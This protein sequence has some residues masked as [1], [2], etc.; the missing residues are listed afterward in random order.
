MSDTVQQI[1]QKL[2][3]V[4]VVSSYIKLH[5]AGKNYKAKSPFTNEKTPSFFVSPDRDMYYCFSS[6][7]GGDIFTFVQEMEGLDFKGALS[8]LAERAGVDIIPFRSESKDKREKLFDLMEEATKYYCSE[9]MQ[10]KEVQQY[11]KGRGLAGKTCAQW[12]VGYAPPG[13][14]TGRAALRR[15]RFTDSDL[16]QA[17]LIKKS[18]K[19][20]SDFYDRFRGRIMFPI[21]DS[22]GR[23]IAFSGRI[24]PSKNNVESQKEDVAKYLNSPDTVLYNK[25]HVLYGYHRAKHSIRKFDFSIVV[26]GQM[27]LL[28]SHQA[29]FSNTVAVSGSSMTD[30][31][32]GLLHRLSSNIVLAFDADRAGITSS[33]RTAELA[34]A[35]G[36]NVKVAVLPPG[37]DP[38]DLVREDPEKWK[39]VVRESEHI[40]D[41]YMD[42]LEQ[43]IGDMRKR[44]LE[45]GKIV[46]PYVAL[47]SNKIDQA[48]FVGSIAGRLGIG[49][50]PVWEELAKMTTNVQEGGK[51]AV[52]AP[53]SLLSPAE[54]RLVGI[55]MWQQKLKNRDVNALDL[56]KR[57]RKTVGDER[58][59]NMFK[60]AKRVEA[61]LLFEVENM[62]EDV[63]AL[64]SD[65]EELL[66]N[67]KRGQLVADRNRILTALQQA[68]QKHND[69]DVESL[70]QKY[71]QLTAELEELTLSS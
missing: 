30:V 44:R 60:S 12:R 42:Y 13:W 16:E 46:L 41:F 27:D 32:L 68:E 52:R 57:V 6:G 26:E 7:K 31:Q 22:A 48:H 50:E 19:S 3:I 2:S 71:A 47:I 38:A 25:S 20:G 37:V 28:M 65:I 69:K 66:M 51:T 14:R 5:K 58:Y 18:E 39:K 49:E 67:L 9:L 61:Q 21:M 1:K 36:M 45:V 40:I 29:G 59:E 62:Y 43:S 56:E 64:H 4:D 35:R 63:T 17:G 53:A 11:L 54:N 70:T 55:I 34:I 15:R 33:G 24:F 10:Q 23:V 8:V